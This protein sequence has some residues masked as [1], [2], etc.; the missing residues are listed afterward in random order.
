[1]RAGLP[2]RQTLRSAR[3]KPTPTGRR[4]LPGLGVRVVVDAAALLVDDPVLEQDLELALSD[5]VELSDGG[6]S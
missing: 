4:N 6:F 2:Q 5:L 1:M 3:G